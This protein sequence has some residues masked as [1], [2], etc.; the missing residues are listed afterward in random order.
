MRG[1]LPF[2][3]IL[4]GSA[5]PVYGWPTNLTELDTLRQATSNASGSDHEVES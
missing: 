4:P 3:T 1:F 2:P 5:S